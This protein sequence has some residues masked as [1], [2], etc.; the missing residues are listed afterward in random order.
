[1]K[2]FADYISANDGI[3]VPDDVLVTKQ[4][5][6]VD[7]KGF[8]TK[9][10]KRMRGSLDRCEII[11][12]DNVAKLCDE[13]G[14]ESD[15][16]ESPPFRPPFNLTLVEY[17]YPGDSR[18]LVGTF[19]EQVESD[20]LISHLLNTGRMVD[21]TSLDVNHKSITAICLF[22]TCL[23][24][25]DF[26]GQITV[27]GLGTLYLNKD[28]RMVCPQAIAFPSVDSFFINS[29]H[30]F[31]SPAILALAFMNCKNV[32]MREVLPDAPLSKK[33]QKKH[34]VPL[35]KYR[36]LEIDAG[37]TVMKGGSRSVNDGDS[38]RS[39]HICRGHFR[40]YTADAPMFGHYVGNV[41]CP[42]HMRGNEK[43]GTIVK[44]YAVNPPKVEVPA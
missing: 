6:L 10:I 18:V 38:E 7:A 31:L 26:P 32:K 35:V 37:R 12:V 4:Q 22:C 11:C 16:R 9:C 2:R 28:G 29:S 23:V 20:D 25:K 14:Y 19:F 3:G 27:F 36:V 13:K 24:R 42:Q 43:H 40:T 1:M 30:I 33:H 21:G 15:L 5:A 34:G 41:W 44:D 17:Q 8:V 39:L